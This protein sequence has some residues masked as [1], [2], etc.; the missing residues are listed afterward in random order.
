MR[1]MPTLDVRYICIWLEI[2][3]K[4]ATVLADIQQKLLAYYDTAPSLPYPSNA[5]VVSLPASNGPDRSMR[6]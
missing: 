1:I 2:S 5:T 6:L 3:H 4:R